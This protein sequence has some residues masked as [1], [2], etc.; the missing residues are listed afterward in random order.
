[1]LRSGLAAT[2]SQEI[3][4]LGNCSDK[5]PS[6]NIWE[7]AL[8]T[9]GSFN[10]ANKA[11]KAIVVCGDTLISDNCWFLDC[12]VVTQNILLAAESLGLEPSIPQIRLIIS[13]L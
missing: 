1:M 13:K 6:N 9:A 4:A 3:G 12:S 7:S 11:D 8:R 10:K 2:S 5:K